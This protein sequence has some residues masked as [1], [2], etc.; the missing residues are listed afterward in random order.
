MQ[1]VKTNNLIERF[2]HLLFFIKAHILI[3]IANIPAK[4][5]RRKLGSKSSNITP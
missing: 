4:P 5:Y 1:E 2:N 3:K